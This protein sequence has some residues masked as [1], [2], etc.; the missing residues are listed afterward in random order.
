[1]ISGLLLGGRKQD[2][3]VAAVKDPDCAFKFT[4]KEFLLFRQASAALPV[5]CYSTVS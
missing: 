4:R 2:F 5:C 1:M 3:N